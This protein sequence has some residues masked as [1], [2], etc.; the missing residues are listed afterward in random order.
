MPE[1]ISTFTATSTL[2]GLA[3]LFTLPGL[4]PAMV[5][6]AFTG[7]IV[8]AATAEEK[9][10]L[11]N[12]TLLIASFITGLLLTDMAADL[13]ANILPVSINVSKA[14]GALI[15]SSMTVRLLQTVIRNQDR[16]LDGLF[17]K[18]NKP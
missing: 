13:L 1:P 9:G 6:G 5:L 15:A 16:L 4:D 11:R 7:A 2:A 8:F 18:R 17:N 12:I 3:M 10:V 14:V